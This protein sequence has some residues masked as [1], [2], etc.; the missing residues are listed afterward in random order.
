MHSHATLDHADFDVVDVDVADVDSW[1]RAAQRALHPAGRPVGT[2]VLEA[3]AAGLATV[4]LPWELSHGDVPVER[5]YRRVLATPAYEAWVICWPS[6]GS[7]DLHDHGGSSGAFSVVSGVLDEASVEAGI[8]VSRKFASGETA[9]FGSSRVHAIVNNGSTAATSV[10]VYSPPLSS[11]VYYA[12][13]GDGALVSA[14]EDIGGWD[15]T[16]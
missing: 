5:R 7:L 2:D 6:G 10:H 13:N 9:S 16:R 15:D 8:T 12:R 3:I 14:G 4:T 11:M 1:K